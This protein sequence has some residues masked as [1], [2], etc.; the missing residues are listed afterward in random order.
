MTRN[1]N[2]VLYSILFAIVMSRLL[3]LKL[4]KRYTLILIKTPIDTHVDSSMTRTPKRSH[5]TAQYSQA[6][7]PHTG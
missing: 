3:K 2:V 6:E 5:A 7:A 4:E 1:S